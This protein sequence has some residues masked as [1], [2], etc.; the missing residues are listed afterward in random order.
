[1]TI[2]IQIFVGDFVIIINYSQ[3]GNTDNKP[4]GV[5]IILN[6]LC[7]RSYIFNDVYKRRSRFSGGVYRSLYILAE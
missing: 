6:T 2:I 3:C 5:F 7:I 4:I 1:M